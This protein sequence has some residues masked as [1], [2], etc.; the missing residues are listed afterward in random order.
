MLDPEAGW[1][2]RG[3]AA[4]MLA[5]ADARGAIASLLDLFFAQT[6]KTELWETALTIE[7]LGDPDVVHPTLI[8]RLS[9]T[10]IPIAAMPP[11]AP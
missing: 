6:D 9:M 4:K 7:H 10:R 1:Y 3:F 8:R 5:L 2:M 11:P